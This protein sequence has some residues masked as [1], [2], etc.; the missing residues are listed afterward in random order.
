VE[1]DAD[2][3]DDG[4]DKFR[5]ELPFVTWRNVVPPDWS[6]GLATL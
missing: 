5:H 1:K 4:E 2:Y 6:G 3:N